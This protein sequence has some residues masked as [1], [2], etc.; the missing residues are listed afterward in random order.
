M[1][2]VRGGNIRRRGSKETET[3]W[4]Q[5][6]GGGQKEKSAAGIWRTVSGSSGD[7]FDHCSGYLSPFR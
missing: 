6:I 1:K 4:S 5:Y 7:H 2:N 3:I